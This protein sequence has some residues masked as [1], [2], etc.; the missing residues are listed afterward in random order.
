MF[1]FS[2]LTIDSF[3]DDLETYRDKKMGVGPLLAD[4]IS[5]SSLL[6][7]IFVEPWDVGAFFFFLEYEVARAGCLALSSKTVHLKAYLYATILECGPLEEPVKRIALKFDHASSCGSD[8]PE[9]I[10]WELLC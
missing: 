9:D 4:L 7:D 10:L 8:I 1:P 6:D 3:Y 5:S 2:F